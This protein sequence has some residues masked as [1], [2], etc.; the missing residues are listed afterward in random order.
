MKAMNF[1]STRRTLPIPPAD[2]VGSPCS[3]QIGYP[4]HLVEALTLRDGTSLAIR[5]I[6]GDDY[7]LEL[8]FIRGLSA[9]SGYLRLLSP[10]KLTNQDIQRLVRIDYAR[11]LALIALAVIDNAVR[12]VGVAR[13][14]PE[15][16]GLSCDFGIV[17]ADEWQGRGLGEA[18]LGSL[19]RAA[20]KAGVP[21]LTG[22]TL[23]ENNAMRK[24][25]RRLGFRIERDPHDATVVQLRMPLRVERRARSRAV[26]SVPIG[27]T[28]ARTVAHNAFSVALEAD[29]FRIEQWGGTLG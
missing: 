17:V 29:D 27:A 9:R 4:S 23:A 15:S 5:P 19:V 12:Q 14:A 3:R 11:E 16:D 28:P 8:D 10:R 13:Y 24:L 22:L 21:E 18:L 25:A 1:T 2:R 26:E 6:C 20:A 7:R